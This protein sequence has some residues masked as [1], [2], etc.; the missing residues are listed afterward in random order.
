M[1]APHRI[2]RAIGLPLACAPAENYSIVLVRLGVGSQAAGVLVGRRCEARSAHAKQLPADR[3]GA[4]Q[5][6]QGKRT[7]QSGAK[8]T[9]DCWPRPDESRRLRLAEHEVASSA[10]RD[11]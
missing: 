9:S 5:L 2:R 1:T 11:G 8:A 6:K 4:V 3:F 10:Q 7:C